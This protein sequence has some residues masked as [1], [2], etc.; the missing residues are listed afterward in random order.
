MQWRSIMLYFGST[1]KMDYR[2][3]GEEFKGWV[4][5]QDGSFDEERDVQRYDFTGRA[6]KD[7]PCPTLHTRQDGLGSVCHDSINRTDMMRGFC[8][9][10]SV[11]WRVQ[12][13]LAHV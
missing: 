4:I 12:C 13:S 5:K 6:W 3:R 9:E 11:V 2:S 10:Y 1:V 8:G 7:V